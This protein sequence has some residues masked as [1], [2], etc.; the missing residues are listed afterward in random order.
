[1]LARLAAYAFI[2]FLGVWAPAQGWGG[3]T[4]APSGGTE[5]AARRSPSASGQP[6][7]EPPAVRS[8]NV[9][10]AWT[11]T[12]DRFN[13][14]RE[15][16]VEHA[17]CR[18]SMSDPRVSGDR[19]IDLTVIFEPAGAT[20]GRWMASTTVRSALGRWRGSG[21]GAAA[22]APEGRGVALYGVVRY[23]GEGVFSR[24]AYT[25]LVAWGDQLVRM[26]GWI[27]SRGASYPMYATYS[28]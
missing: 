26:S 3:P 9:L 10:C 25:E 11:V 8:R 16:L 1:M 23:A 18:A 12:S 13:A 15:V 21:N 19:S 2:L 28:S 17:D 5:G 6:L 27:E 14:G 24:L 22:R 7:P 20:A 4:A